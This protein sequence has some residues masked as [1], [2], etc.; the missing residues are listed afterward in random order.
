M[1]KIESLEIEQEKLTNSLLALTSHFA[2]VQFRLKQIIKSP[3]EEWTDLLG[4]LEE[5]AF[6]G[7][8]EIPDCSN[9]KAP[10]L[11]IDEGQREKQIDMIDQLKTQ[12]EDL[13]KYAFEA[14]DLVLPQTI[15]FEKQKII[16]DEL[17]KKINLPF[18]QKKMAHL[19][20][21]ELKNHI[22]SA[23]GEL[24]NPIKM[25]DHLVNQLKTQI[26]DLERFINFIQYEEIPE[27]FLAKTASCDCSETHNQKKVL[28]RKNSKNKLES[29][30]LTLLDNGRREEPTDGGRRATGQF[31]LPSIYTF[32]E[33]FTSLHMG[34]SPGNH[35]RR[36]V[37]KKTARGNHWG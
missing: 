11:S 15:L 8:P 6:Q 29:R 2:Q 30:E 16:I 9:E 23:M 36:N 28:L 1:N 25:K 17:K 14:G 18:D 37:L 19:S 27:N 22:D 32:F 21:D 5:F 10:K 4:N 26:N 35:F 31:F 20:T 34:N 13:E 7:I 33:M 24:T 3:S 12:L